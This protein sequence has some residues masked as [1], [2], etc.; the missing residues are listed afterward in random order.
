MKHLCLRF[1]HKAHADYAACCACCGYSWDA[2]A[3][4]DEWTVCYGTSLATEADPRRV[5]PLCV[6][7]E[8]P[9]LIPAAAAANA[10]A[11]HL[12]EKRRRKEEANDPTTPF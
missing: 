8:A 10:L 12:D 2:P 11:A 9:E 6:E 4:R 5:C 1:I 7:D 3:V